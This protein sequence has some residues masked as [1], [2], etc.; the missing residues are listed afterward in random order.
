MQNKFEK[1]QD[2]IRQRNIVVF[3]LFGRCGRA[4]QAVVP[5]DYRKAPP[6]TLTV[7]AV[8]R[9]AARDG[10]MRPR[11]IR[12]P[13]CCRLPI[14]GRRGARDARRTPTPRPP[15]LPSATATT[16]KVTRRRS[17]RSTSK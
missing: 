14:K 12:T 10:G 4:R 7:A 2:E 17:D 6:P 15:P 8:A 5:Q 9:D 16:R 1:V 13:R 3:F 11:G